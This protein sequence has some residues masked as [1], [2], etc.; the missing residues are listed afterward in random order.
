MLI[1]VDHPVKR[2]F[3][4]KDGML[5]DRYEPMREEIL[6]APLFGKGRR[7]SAKDERSVAELLA[8]VQADDA[9]AA[10]ALTPRRKAHGVRKAL[11]QFA[12]RAEVPNMSLAY[13]LKAMGGRGSRA[14][15]QR[16]LAACISS[17]RTFAED[18]PAS[19]G[20]EAASVAAYVLGL[21]PDD[22]HAADFLVTL[23]KHPNAG[24]RL[25][26]VWVAATIYANCCQPEVGLGPV[27]T[28]AMDRLL[29]GLR[30]IAVEDDD[31]LFIKAIP[32]LGCFWEN[33]SKK[34]NA[35][36]KRILRGPDASQRHGVVR[37][38]LQLR[39]WPFQYLPLIWGWLRVEPVLRTR[40]HA[41]SQLNGAVPTRLLEELCG[42]GL[43][44]SSPS[45]R[46]RSLLLTRR[47]SP[48]R[49]RLLVASA[50]ENEPDPELRTEMLRI[51]ATSQRSGR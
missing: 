45:L 38:L 29:S 6:Y 46:Y 47:L 30:R 18:A 9:T 1:A 51:V 32:A 41:A 26:A 50:C 31:E 35:R 34:M 43:D 44:D 22:T 15:L 27:R 36:C 2:V 16:T 12:A 48:A 17:A 14:A 20:R 3:E 24:V 8:G 21:D 19:C 49:R 11:A 33:G 13:V 28:R 25:W 5:R 7:R 39:W 4:R 23:F 10:R 37:A 42:R 40:I